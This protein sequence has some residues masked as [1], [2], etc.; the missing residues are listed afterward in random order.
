MAPKLEMKLV[1]D[2]LTDIHTHGRNH[3]QKEKKGGK[4]I[5]NFKEVCDGFGS[6]YK[7]P[8]LLGPRDGGE[9]DRGVPRDPALIPGIEITTIYRYFPKI[10]SLSR[11]IRNF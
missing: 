2:R 10:P 6:E 7:N 9:E 8:D 1:L 3:R 11:K 4:V 5:A